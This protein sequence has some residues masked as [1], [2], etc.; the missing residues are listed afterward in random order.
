MLK[1]GILLLFFSKVVVLPIA[2]S[3]EEKNIFACMNRDRDDP[4]ICSKSISN[5]V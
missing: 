4:F 5:I 2:L 3:P 1:G